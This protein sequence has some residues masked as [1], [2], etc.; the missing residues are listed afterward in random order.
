[1]FD[2]LSPTATAAST[3]KSGLHWTKR[4]RRWPFPSQSFT[5]FTLSQFHATPIH[6]SRLRVTIYFLFPFSLGGGGGKCP[7]WVWMK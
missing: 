4:V 3:M 6:D 7:F 5:G 1:M 2:L